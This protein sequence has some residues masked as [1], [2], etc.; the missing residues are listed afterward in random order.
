MGKKTKSDTNITDKKSKKSA[1]SDTN[2]TANHDFFKA[3][4]KEI[5]QQMQSVVIGIYEVLDEL[6]LKTICGENLT[7][8]TAE[9]YISLGTTT[10][11]SNAMGIFDNPK[12]MNRI[13]TKFSHGEKSYI[14]VVSS[15]ALEA[16]ESQTD[17]KKLLTAITKTGGILN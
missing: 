12:Y 6:K 10:I 3:L 11:F 7:N 13:I 16:F 14:L 2:I 15:F 4:E 17:G 9:K 1:K 8:I 5:K